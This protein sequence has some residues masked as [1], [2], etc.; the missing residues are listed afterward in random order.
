MPRAAIPPLFSSPF[1]I[2]P[3][4]STR[5]T[6]YHSRGRQPLHH[7]PH[8]RRTRRV[9][10]DVINAAGIVIDIAL[11]AS[12]LM[13]ST[14][15]ASSST[16][17]SSRR[18]VLYNFP[19]SVTWR[20]M[21]TISRS[22][23]IFSPRLIRDCSCRRHH[24]HRHPHRRRTHR[25]V[26]MPSTL[27][28]SSSTSYSS[29]RIVQLPT[30]CHLESCVNNLTKHLDLVAV[31]YSQLSLLPASSSPPSSSTSYSSRRIVQ[32]PPASVP[33]KVALTILGNSSIFSQRLIRDCLCARHHHRYALH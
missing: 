9:L 22:T 12:Y 7:H 2:R 23:S 25:V 20:A 21:L 32:P 18:I 3:S 33:L 14:P 30:V 17:Y 31:S 19:L 26:P 1:I 6:C 11:V 27:P 5:L 16:S 24:P 10:T 28:A 29:R 13:P 8:R 15:P 4:H